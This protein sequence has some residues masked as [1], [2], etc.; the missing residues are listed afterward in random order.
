MKGAKVF[1]AGYGPEQ[2]NAITEPPGRQQ[3]KKAKKEPGVETVKA[4][5]CIAGKN[6]S[7]SPR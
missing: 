2:P 3:P 1:S 7:Q 4:Y 5:T 6:K